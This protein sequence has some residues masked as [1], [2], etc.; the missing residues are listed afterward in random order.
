MR[1]LIPSVIDNTSTMGRTMDIYSKLLGNRIIFIEGEITS[2]S[3]SLVVAQLIYL[4][5]QDPTKDINIYINSPGGSV[6]AGLAIY[7]TMQFIT[8]DVSTLCMGQAASMGAFLLASGTKGKRYG[9]PNSEIMLH[10]VIGGFHGQASDVEIAAK[11]ISQ[12]KLI[13][14]KI[15]AERTGRTIE[16]IMKDTDRDFYLTSQ[17]ALD[18]GVI[19]EIKITRY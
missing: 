1:L 14:N 2:E 9:L 3:A 12:T 19:D 13:I 4:E 8:C 18:Y 17:E 10:Q 5:N 11:R 16:S 15:I 7:D 6:I